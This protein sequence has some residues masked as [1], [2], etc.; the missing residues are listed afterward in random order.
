MDKSNKHDVG[1]KESE[2][3]EEMQENV[4]YIKHKSMQI[5]I[6]QIK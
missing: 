3:M 4:I 1:Q 5:D 6:H 2:R